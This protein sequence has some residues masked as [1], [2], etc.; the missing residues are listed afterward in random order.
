M[1]AYRK[2]II[3]VNV[4][5]GIDYKLGTVYAIFAAAA[6]I[7]RRNETDT[8]AKLDTVYLV[9]AIMYFVVSAIEWFGFAA[10]YKQS[11]RLVRYYF[12]STATAALI[13]TAAEILRIVVHFTDKVGRSCSIR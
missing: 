8:S 6:V 7:R 13:V 11:I 2:L 3:L 10:A 1:F 9:M 5:H 12:W 4:S